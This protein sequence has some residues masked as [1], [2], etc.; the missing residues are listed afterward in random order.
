MLA[1]LDLMALRNRRLCELNAIE[2]A[3]NVCHTTMVMDAWEHGQ[4]LS[5]HAWCYSLDDGH[6][7]DLSMHVSSRA[8]LQPAYELALDRLTR[9]PELPR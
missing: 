4:N 6:V 7:N 8:S 9:L 5:V 2:Q 3:V 1:S